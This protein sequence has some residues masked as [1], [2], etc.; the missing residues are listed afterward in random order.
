M[1]IYDEQIKK[2]VTFFMRITHDEQIKRIVYLMG[3]TQDQQIKII[4]ICFGVYK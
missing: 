4:D 3:S 1:G 2:K